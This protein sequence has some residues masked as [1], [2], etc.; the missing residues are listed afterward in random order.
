QAEGLRDARLEGGVGCL[1]VGAGSH[2]QTW[3][4]KLHLPD[5]DHVDEAAFQERDLLSPLHGF[6]LR[7]RLDQVEAAQRLLG[8][9]EGAV[10]DLPVAGLDTDAAGVSVRAQAL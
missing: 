2:E 7:R 9:G 4:A 8:L 6:L 1:P 5:G 3:Y 10:H